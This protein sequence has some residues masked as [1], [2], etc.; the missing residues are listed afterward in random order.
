[1]DIFLI[2]AVLTLLTEGI[3][4]LI[5][6]LKYND[7]IPSDIK[8][9]AILC[10][11]G[12]LNDVLCT[13]LAYTI[14]DTTVPGNIYV[15]IEFF[16]LIVQFYKWK[17]IGKFVAIVLFS[18][19]MCVWILEM[20]CLSSITQF[21]GIYRTT[22]S[23]IVVFLAIWQINRELI[24]EKG[25]ILVNP[26][27]LICISCVFYYA[28]KCVNELLYM[29]RMPFYNMLWNILSFSN[30]AVQIV[31]I[32]AFLCLSTRKKFTLR[33]WFHC[34]FSPSLFSFL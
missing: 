15:L 21:G 25:R 4:A 8:A 32:I 3:L 10:I 34:Q 27:F 12:F 16:L 6:L 17:G 31:Y 22:Y 13:I 26:V 14:R 30:V 24:Y 19:G 29:V 28:Y 7:E 23:F 18:I 9:F 2:Q 1:M 20:F 11:I 33:Y 5:I